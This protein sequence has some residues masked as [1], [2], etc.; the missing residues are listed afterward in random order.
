RALRFLAVEPAVSVTIEAE[1]NADG[2]V[3]VAIDDYA[4]GTVVLADRYPTPPV[5]PGRPLSS[6]G[7]CEVSPAALYGDRWMFHGPRFQCV[8]ELGPIADDGIRGVLTA[9]P[10]PGA[11]LDNAGQLLGFWIMQRMRED[12]LAFPASIERIH[13]YGPQPGPGEAVSC[14]V[15]ISSVTDTKVSADLEL[16]VGGQLYAR[17]DRWIDRR[18]RT[19]EVTWPT[20]FFPER[21]RIAQRQ[22]GGVFLVRDRW[23]DL[24][25]QELAVRRYLSKAERTE[26]SQRNPRTARQWLLGRIAVKDAVRQSLWDTGADPIY[27]VEITVG[28]D[29]SGRPFVTGPFAVPPAISLAHSGPLAVALVGHTGK[30]PGVDIELV[31]DRDA[32]T[33]AAIMTEAERALLTEVCGQ[34]PDPRA[35]R[36][37]WLTRF[38]TAKE[39]AAKAEGTGLGGRKDLFVVEQVTGDRLLVRNHR[40]HADRR[41]RWTRTALGTAPEPYALAWTEGGETDDA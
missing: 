15:R 10:T 29:E 20:F 22:P 30:P 35:A 38:W 7:P 41:T 3:A 37:S 24:G 5:T 31:K 28:N 17:I 23:G 34:S 14:V 4:N 18:F 36:A 19:D 32:E 9:S 11:L 25:S 13:L 6:E 39:A 33:E 12:R 27:P 1:R 26:Y 16:R 21:N 8:A 40:D 2:S